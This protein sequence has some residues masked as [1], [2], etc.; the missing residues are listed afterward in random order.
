MKTRLAFSIATAVEPDILIADEILAV[1]DLKFRKKCNAKM[2]EMLKGGTTLLYVSHNIASVKKQCS[3]AMWLDHGNIIMVGDSAKVCDAFQK[4][5]ESPVPIILGGARDGGP[6]DP[7]TVMEPVINTL[8]DAE[9]IA[10]AA[11]KAAAEAEKKAASAKKTAAAA[12]KKAEA[13]KKAAE[14][15]EKK[16][17]EMA[18]VEHHDKVEAGAETESGKAGASAESDPAEEKAETAN[19]DN[20]AVNVDN[21][22]EKP[23]E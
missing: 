23:Q 11:K 14:E 6:V 7:D 18:E 19:V 13:A 22:A 15:A 10:D 3:K 5:M 2:D 8:A 21:E 16:A 1:G 4:E 9:I 12:A 17:E 20:K